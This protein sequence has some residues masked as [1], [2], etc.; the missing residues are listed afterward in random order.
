MKLVAVSGFFNPIHK[1]HIAYLKEAA[2]LGTSLIVILGTDEQ[3]KLKGSVPFMAYDERREILLA[4]GCVD[5][6]V[7]ATDK[8]ITVRHTLSWLR[9]HI[10][11][12]GGD[13]TKSNTP[14]VKV[15]KKLGIDIVYNV[16]GA[17]SQ[18]SSE[19]LANAKKLGKL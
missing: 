1:G 6:V 9:P 16:G 8:D 12:K 2:K 18:S 3:V 11:A 5:M 13:R 14:E 19:L 10:F 4:I 17:K 15:C 7:K